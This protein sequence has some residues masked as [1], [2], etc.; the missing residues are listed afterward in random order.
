LIQPVI[1]EGFGFAV[2]DDRFSSIPLRN[3]ISGK[4]FSRSATTTRSSR[5][6]FSVGRNNH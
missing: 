4:T 2:I 3:C 1:P 6:Q 5:Q